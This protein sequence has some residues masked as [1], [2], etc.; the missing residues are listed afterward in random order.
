[1]TLVEERTQ[2]YEAGLLQFCDCEL[3]QRA[4]RFYAE[5]SGNPYGKQLAEEARQRRIGY[6]HKIDGL[7]DHEREISMGD[8]TVTKHNREAIEA[9]AAAVQQRTGLITLWGKFGV[10][11]TGLMMA[12]VN[13]CRNQDMTAMYRTTADMLAWLRAGFDQSQKDGEDFSYEKRWSLLT[14]VGCLALDEMTAY[15][16]TP[17]ASERFERL[18]D[19]RWRSMPDLLT[20]VAFNADKVEFMK[21]GLPDV[22]ESRLRDRR[23]QW[24]NMGGMDMRQ[25]RN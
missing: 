6:L 16:A 3:G 12:A 9:V 24:I 1:M 17:W 22:V 11:K 15:S 10:G 19:E 5:R 18:I 8:F 7:K 20:I 25:I 13:A 21:S 4:Q 2:Q 14:R 23:A